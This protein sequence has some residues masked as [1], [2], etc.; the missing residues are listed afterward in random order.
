L[1]P[2]LRYAGFEPLAG[3]IRH[4]LPHVDRHLPAHN[5][6]S[7]LALCRALG[8]RGDENTEAVIR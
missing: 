7:L 8:G 1:N 6:D 2:L 3:G 5:V 4:M